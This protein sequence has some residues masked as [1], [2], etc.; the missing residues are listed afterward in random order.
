MA[1]TIEYSEQMLVDRLSQF[2]D[3]RYTFDHIKTSTVFRDYKMAAV[4]VP[5]FIKDGDVHVLLTVRSAKMRR[6]KGEV[7]FPG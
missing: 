5:L 4:L 7:A 2:H 6:H 1:K 3:T